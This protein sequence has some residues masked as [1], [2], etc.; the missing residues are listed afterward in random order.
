MV[1]MAEPKKT[2]RKAGRPKTGLPPRKPSVTLKRSEEWRDWL[3]AF[4]EHCHMP[5]TVVIDQA[6]IAYAESRGFDQAMPKR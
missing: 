4:A 6:L 3:N 5:A 1:A 2:K